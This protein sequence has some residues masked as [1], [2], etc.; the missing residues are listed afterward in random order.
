MATCPVF[1]LCYTQGMV[2]WLRAGLAVL[3]LLVG[4]VAAC[5]IISSARQAPPPQQ[6]ATAPRDAKVYTYHGCPVFTANDWFTT[7]LVTGRGRYVPATVDPNSANIINNINANVGNI[8][9]DR[10]WVRPTNE[11]VNLDDE[12]PSW[13]LTPI[14]GLKWGFAND[15]YNDD[16]PPYRIPVTNGTFYQEGTDMCEQP[17]QDCHVIVLD[18]VKCVDYETFFK[19]SRAYGNYRLRSW[20]DGSFWAAAGGVENLRHPYQIENINVTGAH[21]SMMGTTDWGEDATTYDR[22]SCRATNSCVIPHIVAFLL[23][24][25]GQANGGYVDP[26]QGQQAKCSSFCTYPLPEGA[27]LRLHSRYQCPPAS[28]YPQANLLCNQLKQYGMILNDFTGGPNIGGIRLGLSADGTNPWNRKDYG[29]LFK[30]IH[31]ADF[32]VITLGTIHG[33]SNP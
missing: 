7:N 19:G 33:S 18:T 9:F 6:V 13:L 12:S 30:R 1:V 31:V 15:P 10:G 27:R 17:G 14:N 8:D 16:P 28:S 29:Q 3:V 5:R 4:A 26:A 24:V 25:A 21:I 22:A 11:A 23:P 2:L 32:D 20:Y